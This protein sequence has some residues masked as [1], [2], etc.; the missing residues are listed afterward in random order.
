MYFYLSLRL[1]QFPQVD[2]HFLQRGKGV[3]TSHCGGIW[4]AVTAEQ[5]TCPDPSV[6]ASLTQ[7][8][9]VTAESEL[10]KYKEKQTI[11]T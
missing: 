2:C 11:P 10:S 4:Q 3:I 7:K 6:G 8:L 9:Y 5:P 1:K